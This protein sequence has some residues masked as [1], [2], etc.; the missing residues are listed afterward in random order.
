MRDVEVALGLLSQDYLDAPR[1]SS[2][3]PRAWWHP[4]ISISAGLGP[5]ADS[6]IF[7]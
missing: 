3:H 1:Y 5:G 2:A 6:E 7:V 4:A